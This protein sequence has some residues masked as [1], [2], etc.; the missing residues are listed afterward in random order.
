MTL[1]EPWFDD[2]DKRLADTACRLCL[3]FDLCC[4]KPLDEMMLCEVPS[5]R[6]LALGEVT[7]IGP[8]ERA[9]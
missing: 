2:E 4:A 8:A 1:P 5:D 7:E 6:E 9:A 3:F